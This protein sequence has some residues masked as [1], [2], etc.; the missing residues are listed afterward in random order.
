MAHLN[1]MY[2]C[3]S[4]FFQP[5]MVSI[6]S[7]LHNR[8]TTTYSIYVFA[9]QFTPEQ[10]YILEEKAKT[11]FSTINVYDIEPELQSQKLVGFGN[12]L[13]TPDAL[14]RMYIPT[15]FD[16]FER[17]LYLDADVV[18]LEDLG[19]L[20]TI[21]LEDY[22]F[23][24]AMDHGAMYYS[25][26]LRDGEELNE[27]QTIVFERLKK[28]G[29]FNPETIEIEYFNSG[30]ML[31]NIAACLKHGITTR[32][33]LDLIPQ[34]Q[35]HLYQDQDLLNYISFKHTDGFKHL[36]ISYNVFQQALPDDYIPTHRYLF[37]NEPIN[38]VHFV[39]KPKPWESREARGRAFYM[40]YLDLADIPLF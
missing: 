12:G 36:P 33:L 29:R 1:V 26:V 24:A 40:Y 21:D 8:T 28:G 17:V 2:A 16:K 14:S 19:E 35:E 15:F 37:D 10:I 13:Y 32:Y 34:F 3:N 4:K 5:L 39:S 31:W 20:A 18:V 25:Q 7:L 22:L 6:T 30:V 23:G 11:E 38:I 27:D 9:T